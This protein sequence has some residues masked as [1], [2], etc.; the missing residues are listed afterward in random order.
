[1]APYIFVGNIEEITRF[2]EFR[3]KKVREE[4]NCNFNGANIGRYLSIKMA[5]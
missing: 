5:I 1:M 4:K 3:Q 2:S